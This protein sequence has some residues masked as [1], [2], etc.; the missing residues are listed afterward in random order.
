MAE[1]NAAE[2]KEAIARLTKEADAMDARI[3]QV[4]EM[5]ERG[6]WFCEDG[7]EVDAS[8]Y[9]GDIATS[10]VAAAIPVNK[11]EIHRLV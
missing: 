3:S 1:R 4:A 6:F 9:G 5:E 2:T 10:E 11:N 7:H 8:G